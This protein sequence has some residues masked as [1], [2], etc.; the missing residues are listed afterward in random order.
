MSPFFS[1][2][3]C[4]PVS[5]SH[6]FPIDPRYML[7]LSVLPAVLQFFGFIFLPESPRWLLQKG[8]SQEARQVLG[9]IWGDRNIEEEYDTIRTSIEEEENETGSGLRDV[10]NSRLP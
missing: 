3:F 7:G 6:F 10:S 1:N 2:D 5:S 8:R 9:R 4:S